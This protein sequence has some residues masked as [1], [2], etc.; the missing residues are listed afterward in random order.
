[1]IL[2]NISEKHLNSVVVRRQIDLNIVGTLSVYF[3]KKKRKLQ[4][5]S[6]RNKKIALWVSIG[7]DM[8]L[9]SLYCR[10]IL[11]SDNRRNMKIGK[12]LGLASPHESL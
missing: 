9:N 8:V 12:W 4:T 6:L 11:A 2:S 3:T 5:F 1:M 10:D 7:L